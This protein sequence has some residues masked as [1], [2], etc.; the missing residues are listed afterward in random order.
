M[1]KRSG[2][3]CVHLSYVLSN[4]RVVECNDP[5]K[6][7]PVWDLRQKRWYHK[8][9]HVQSNYY[10]GIPVP[11]NTKL[12]RYTVLPSKFKPRKGGKMR[13]A[14][15]RCTSNRGNTYDNFQHNDSQSAENFTF[16]GVEATLSQHVEDDSGEEGVG[17]G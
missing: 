14:R 7:S 6:N 13:K 5:Y 9:W 8:V 3:P 10:H 16:P 17:V 2:R 12:T 4:W 15:I 1:E 11:A